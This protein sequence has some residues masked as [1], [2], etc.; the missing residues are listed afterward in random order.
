MATSCCCARRAERDSDVRGAVAG[1]EGGRRVV[2]VVV[3]R[4][5]RGRV[6]AGAPSEAQAC[7]G[8]RA[9]LCELFV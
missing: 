6:T 7:Q 3:E 9:P 2:V 8:G 5:G 1:R 4:R